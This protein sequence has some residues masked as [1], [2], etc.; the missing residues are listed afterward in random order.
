MRLYGRK[1]SGGNAEGDVIV[2]PGAVSFLGGVDPEE[3][4]IVDS[5]NHIYGHSIAGKIFAF[6]TGKGSTVGSYVIY[7]MKKSGTA[8]AAIINERAETITAS[9]AIIS[10][11]P[12]IDSID[13]SLLRDCDRVSVNANEAYVELPGVVMKEAI[14][15]IIRK[16]DRVLIL[17]RSE[18]VGSCRGRWAGVSG[19]IEKWDESIESRVMEEIEE[20]TGIK[21]K[22]VRKGEPVLARERSVIWKIHPFLAETS[23]EPEIDWEHSKYRWISPQEVYDYNTVPKLDIVLRNLGLL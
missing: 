15:A 2:E 13:I 20:E 17:K 6:S 5:S 9:G 21:A 1:L 12:M 4:I 22:I 3:G 18:K 11:I 8:P 14:T 7:R 16:K 23:E 10:E 19:Y